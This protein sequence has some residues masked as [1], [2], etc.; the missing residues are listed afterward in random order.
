MT[1][2]C[3]GSA[4]HGCVVVSRVIL[5]KA[6]LPPPHTFAY[7]LTSCR[8]L[9]PLLFDLCDPTI[10]RS[11]TAV[12]FNGRQV[13]CFE[14]DRTFDQRYIIH[15]MGILLSVVKFGGQGFTKIAKATPITRSSHA[16]MRERARNGMWFGIAFG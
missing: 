6:I 3:E 15:V 16:A 9:D 1:L 11:S 7:S 13:Q 8:I 14:Y 2:T 10:H 12:A 4:R 5:G